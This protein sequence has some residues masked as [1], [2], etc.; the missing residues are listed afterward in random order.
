M[1]TAAGRAVTAGLDIRT[2]AKMVRWPD[3]FMSEG[4]EAMWLRVMALLD[5]VEVAQ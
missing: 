1:M 4:A 3:R 2:E 5:Y